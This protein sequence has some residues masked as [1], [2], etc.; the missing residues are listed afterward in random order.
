MSIPCKA[1]L[2]P[3]FLAA[4]HLS[5][6]AQN[7]DAPLERIAFGSCLHQEADQDAIWKAVRA[8]NPQ[9][10]VF[11]GDAVYADTRNKEEFREAWQ[12]LL[13]QPGYQALK[14]ETPVLATWDDH[15]FGE[16]DAGGN[17]P[18]RKFSKELFFDTFEVPE[19]SPRRD[20]DGIYD[21]KIFGPEGQR[22]QVILLDTRYHRSPLHR[23]PD[24]PNGRRGAYKPLRDG[25]ATFLGEA[26]WQWLE[27]QLRQPA[28]VRLLVSSIQVVS[29]Q[30]RYEKW[31]NIPGE[32]QRLLRLIEDTG[33]EG[34]VILSGDRHHAELSRLT[35]EVPY[36]L[37][38][39]TS[40]GMTQSTPWRS[41]R[42][43]KLERNRYRVGT[44]HRGHHFGMVEVDWHR[45]EP[46]LTL[47]IVGKNGATHLQH[48]ILMSE[49]T[50]QSPPTTGPQWRQ[51]E[52][53][54][55][56]RVDGRF[57]DWPE[58]RY[59]RVHE[60]WLHGRFRLPAGKVGLPASG[61][62]VFIGMD[63]DLDRQSGR[64]GV[65]GKGLEAALYLNYPRG[66]DDYPYAT[67][68]LVDWTEDGRR[69]T[70]AEIG[71]ELGPTHAARQYEFA[72]PLEKLR[73]LG[74]FAES[75]VVRC[76]IAFVDH[77]SSAVA[78]VRTLEVALP[79]APAPA[80]TPAE[81]PAK[82][83]GAVRVVAYNVLWGSPQ[84]EPAS[85]ARIF[86]ALG[87]DLLLL[88]EW[89]RERDNNVEVATWF[90]EHVAGG[91]EVFSAVAGGDPGSWGGVA[92]VTPHQVNAR[93]PEWNRVVG[94][95]WDFP[96]R[97]A[98][99]VIDSPQGRI[100]AGSVHLKA[101]GA[102]V[103]SAEDARRRAEAPVVNELMRGAASLADPGLVVLGGDF[104]LN[105]SPEILTRCMDHLDTDGSDLAV[106]MSG[107]LGEPHLLNTFRKAR[108]GIRLDYI[109]FSESTWEA[110]NAFV[111]DTRNI[112][113]KAL[114][115]AAL[116]AEDVMG[117]DH[118]PV[119]LDLVR[120]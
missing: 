2:F 70:A 81:L 42:P 86:R 82:P 66:E 9:L 103:D 7:D 3:V 24:E 58:G 61:L 48:R 117:S 120:R 10:F 39:F 76:S 92:I 47:R 68:F 119:V 51:Q 69:Y 87:A 96:L 56:A 72:L 22:V 5:L 38:D 15:D 106:A 74:A 71:W 80:T 46:L 32:R 64:A 67:D 4:G 79:S 88:Q 45:P 115:A 102:D 1:L 54:A 21:A 84:E 26:Q 44:I 75:A 104:N 29:A 85:F 99:A 78:P 14:A 98:G 101:S 57:L 34:V 91:E 40:S 89:D 41:G 20:R 73:E 13:D 95:G 50:P 19:D 23:Y 60:G 107:L 35:D 65:F 36:S 93:L 97:M 94:G 18:L 111:V 11:A 27:E 100:L 30:H 17:Y 90:N 105:G 118:L 12:K 25:D 16:N 31:A 37:Y 108:P 110:V 33:A 8:E 116:Q 62:G 43:D 52:G 28:E 83:E 77:S 53:A 59:L 6:S 63:T 55:P 49:L 109:G 113:P 112:P 114:R